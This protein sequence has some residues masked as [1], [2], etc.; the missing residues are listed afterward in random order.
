MAG[1]VYQGAAASSTAHV[2]VI[3]AG[4][5]ALPGRAESPESRSAWAAKVFEDA[6]R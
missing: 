2:A 3:R 4:V 6:T 1:D 5:R